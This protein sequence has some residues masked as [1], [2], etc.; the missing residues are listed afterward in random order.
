LATQVA[1]TATVRDLAELLD[2]DMNQ[3]AGVLVLI[4]TDPLTGDPV[5]VA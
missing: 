5:E 4:A 1:P 3:V 2:V